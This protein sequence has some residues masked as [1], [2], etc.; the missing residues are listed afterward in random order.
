MNKFI[1][2]QGSRLAAFAVG[3]VLFSSA[4]E[5][6]NM[7]IGTTGVINNQGTIKFRS[8]NGNLE[9]NAPIGNITNDGNILILGTT[10][11]FNGTNTLTS[12][13]ALR[14]PGLVTYGRIAVGAQR[15]FNGYY[16]DVT[17]DGLS[18]KDLTH[19]TGVNSLNYFVGGDYTITATSGNRNYAGSTFTYD[20]GAA[21]TL[22]T[23]QTVAGENTLNGTGYNN[24]AFAQDAVKT[25]S[26]IATASGTTDVLATT[27]GGGGVIVTGATGSLTSAGNFTQAPLAGDYSINAGASTTLNGTLNSIQA[28]VAVNDGSL[29]LGTATVTNITGVGS[30]LNLASSTAN[31]SK[32]DLDAT[33]RLNVNGMFAN[34][35]LS[36]T[37][38]TYDVTSIVEYQ[39]AATGGI[40]TTAS[41]N[42]YGNLKLNRTTSDIQANG[43]LAGGVPDIN[44][45]T[46]IAL[47]GGFDLDMIGTTDGYVN[48]QAASTND[49]VY[50]AQEE[51]IGKFRRTHALATGTDYVYGNSATTVNFSTAPTGGTYFQVNMNKDGSTQQYDNTRDINRD[52]NIAYD[53]TGFVAAVKVGYTQ[54]D[55]TEATWT[56]GYT[57]DQ[58]R[59]LEGK[60]DGTNIERIGTGQAYA[61]VASTPTTFGTVALP[62]ITYTAADVDGIGDAGFFSSNELILRA[63]PGV[64]ASVQ[65]G[66][67]S[68]PATWDAGEQPLAFDSVLVRHNVWAG[69][70]RTIDGFAGD[71]LHPTE[72]A[73]AINIISPSPNVGNPA[74]N[75]PTP[76]LMIGYSDADIVSNFETSTPSANGTGGVT[77]GALGAAT[78]LIPSILN[79]IPTS[80]VA[81]NY[82]G[83][84]LIF[85]NTT[86]AEIPELFVKGSVLNNGPL[87]IG[88]I[89][90]IGQ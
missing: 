61:R 18:A 65:P 77:I 74:L 44:V 41:T 63:G 50:N 84:L 46:S 53:N 37:N 88:G 4:A 83:G 7:V 55:R 87:N 58:I 28:L 69:F 15:I 52:V 76:T 22:A 64:V 49:V 79:E 34:A 19:N 89:L 10:Q 78:P 35:D 16:D 31:T 51:V 47:A 42:P 39:D 70:T 21:T 67:W 25:L 32:L 68:N 40:I 72:L 45:A 59:F 86:T 20:G 26:S 12:T 17:I 3:L 48:L 6:Q 30:N 73:A 90:S 75:F 38:T 82:V 2:K 81:T 14:I 60:A 66:R 54:T 8:D 13:S 85:G 33:A 11:T 29:N 80:D 43:T 57:E 27:G 24:L 36:R 23:T 5:A 62:G 9:N 1:T 56:A 71:E